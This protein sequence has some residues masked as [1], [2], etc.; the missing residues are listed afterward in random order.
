[1]YSAPVASQKCACCSAERLP[2]GS[3][4]MYAIVPAYG[5]TGL[6]RRFGSTGHYWRVK[7]LELFDALSAT[8]VGSLNSEFDAAAIVEPSVNG[9]PIQ[10]RHDEPGRRVPLEFLANLGQLVNLCLPGVVETCRPNEHKHLAPRAGAD[11]TR[12]DFRVIRELH[13]DSVNVE[14][15]PRQN[16]GVVPR[17]FVRVQHGRFVRCRQNGGDVVSEESAR[18]LG[19]FGGDVFEPGKQL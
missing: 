5:S 8:Q 6:K 1:M 13:F 14:F 2:K 7:C 12:N 4:G 9:V 19:V 17:Q 11:K 16:L 15:A 3:S 10:L 18:S